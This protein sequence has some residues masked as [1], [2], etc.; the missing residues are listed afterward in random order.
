MIDFLRALR[1]HAA[2]KQRLLSLVPAFVVSE[3]F[4]KFHSFALECT[5]FLLTWL[6]FDLVT[7]WVAGVPVVSSV[8]RGVSKSA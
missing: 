5:G 2:Y 3:V 6:A 1:A 4:Y 8:S 7:E